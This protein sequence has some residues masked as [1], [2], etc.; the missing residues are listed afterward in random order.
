MMTR[1]P[2]QANVHTF[3][4][5]RIY[6]GTVFPMAQGL[7]CQAF[8]LPF[9]VCIDKGT[10]VSDGHHGPLSTQMKYTVP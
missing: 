9:A 6:S 4:S 3:N 2:T 1:D 7:C 5:A 8:V 10:H